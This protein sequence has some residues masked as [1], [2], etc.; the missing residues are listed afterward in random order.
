MALLIPEV[1]RNLH[2][3]IARRKYL[4][5]WAFGQTFAKHPF[6]A[7]ISTLTHMFADEIPVVVKE[8]KLKLMAYIDPSEGKHYF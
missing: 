3:G 2:E 4:S 8:S 5:I 1:G 6:I 7:H